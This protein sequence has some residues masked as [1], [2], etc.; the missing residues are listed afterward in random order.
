MAGAGASADP[1]VSESESGT[2]L[3][4]WVLCSAGVER[5][6]ARRCAVVGTVPPLTAS[7]VGTSG[8]DT[9]AASCAAAGAPRRLPA[10]VLAGAGRE[11]PER[12]D[13]SPAE[14]AESPRPVSAAAVALKPRIAVPT[15]S[16]TASAP[17]RPTWWVERRG[18]VTVRPRGRPA[19]KALR[20]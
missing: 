20:R 16:A 5:P 6:A 13:S 1:A 7:L 18:A 8:A 17:T 12:L 19:V 15:P 4:S 2:S 14:P 11:F 3:R 10:R 9:G